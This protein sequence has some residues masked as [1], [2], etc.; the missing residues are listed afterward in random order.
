MKNLFYEICVENRKI[1]FS[2]VNIN[3]FHKKGSSK[4]M[5]NLFYEIC[6]KNRKIIFSYLNI[7][8][9]HK[10]IYFK[11]IKFYIINNIK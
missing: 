10:K 11:I 2:Y 5:K 7:N 9:F 1:I 8:K 4:K 3:K 6:V